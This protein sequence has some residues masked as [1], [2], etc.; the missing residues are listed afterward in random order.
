MATRVFDVVMRHPSDPSDGGEEG[1]HPSDRG[2][3]RR[4]P[5]DRGCVEQFVGAVV[6]VVVLILVAVVVCA[7]VARCICPYRQMQEHP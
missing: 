2:R 4:H 1:K 3:E 6:L 7:V 5:S